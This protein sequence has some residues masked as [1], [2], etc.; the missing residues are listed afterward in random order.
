MV[1]CV[2]HVSYWGQQRRV[3]NHL[4]A[5]RQHWGD[6]DFCWFWGVCVSITCQLSRAAI[7]SSGWVTQM[8]KWL[9]QHHFWCWRW[10]DSWALLADSGLAPAV[11]F[12]WRVSW[13]GRSDLAKFPCPAGGPA[14][15]LLFLFSQMPLQQGAR[16]QRRPGGRSWGAGCPWRGALLLPVYGS[17]VGVWAG[18][19]GPLC[20]LAFW[21][22]PCSP[23]PYSLGRGG[24]PPHAGV[25]DPAPQGVHAESTWWG[26]PRFVSC[27]CGT[28]ES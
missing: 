20:C 9:A 18:V 2:F 16:P 24:C 14:E 10:A 15:R 22:A 27:K 1:Y 13:A 11:T 5:V 17:R 6:S 12:R 7:W 8:P 4:A 28:Q 19:L 25:R 26:W 21:R 3:C 23:S